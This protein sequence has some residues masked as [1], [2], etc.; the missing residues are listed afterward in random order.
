[1]GSHFKGRE[2]KGE[3]VRRKSEFL[4]KVRPPT[5]ECSPSGFKANH[6][7]RILKFKNEKK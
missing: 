1:M 7:V 5:V 3:S 2:E 4:G 6:R